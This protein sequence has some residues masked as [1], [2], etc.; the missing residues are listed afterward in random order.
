MVRPWVEI[1]ALAVVAKAA[2]AAAGT[3]KR[4]TNMAKDVGRD[5]EGRGQR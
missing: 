3:A 2:R 1:W 4:E 5:N